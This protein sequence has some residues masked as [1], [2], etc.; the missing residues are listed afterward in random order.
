MANADLMQKAGNG[1]ANP[2][3][4]GGDSFTDLAMK[5]SGVDLSVAAGTEAQQAAALQGVLEAGQG[6][7]TMARQGLT[8]LASDAVK[9]EIQDSVIDQNKSVQTGSSVMGGLGAMTGWMTGNKVGTGFKLPTGY[10]YTK[11]YG[12]Q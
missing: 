6:K 8:D 7:A 5:K 11:S 4:G 1:Q 9:A 2:N 3:R 10:D 12:D